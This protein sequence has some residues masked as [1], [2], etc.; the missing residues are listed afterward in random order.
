MVD[1]K[2]KYN[3]FIGYRFRLQNFDGIKDLKDTHND[4]LGG[5]C[6]YVDDYNLTIY[7]NL[8]YEVGQSVSI[9]GYPL[10]KRYFELL[11]V[12]ITSNP[13]IE[14]AKITKKEVINDN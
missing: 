1:F 7:T 4:F 14:G 10:S 13:R 11:E 5:Y 12:S 9:G 2:Y 8:S 3:A 6:E